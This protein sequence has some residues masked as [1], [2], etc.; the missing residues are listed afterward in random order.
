MQE[1]S[2]RGVHRGDT[3]RRTFPGLRVPEPGNGRLELL[4]CRVRELPVRKHPGH[5][6]GLVLRHPPV[7][8]LP[9]RQFPT[10]PG[11]GDRRPRRPGSREAPLDS[12]EVGRDSSRGSTWSTAGACWTSLLP[13]E[14]QPERFG[15]IIGE[16]IANPNGISMEIHK[17]AIF[18]FRRRIDIQP[19][20][21]MK[22]FEFAVLEDRSR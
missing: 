14:W 5:S 13:F 9:V 19:F 15:R 17:F 11:G 12:G 2:Q 20:A 10:F 6:Q 3:L 21:N 18:K 16:F 1:S 7:P 22:V 4:G 8:R